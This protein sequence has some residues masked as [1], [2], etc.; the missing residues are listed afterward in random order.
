MAVAS[1]E[2]GGCRYSCELHGSGVGDL[3]L[4]FLTRSAC[5]RGL[6]RHAVKAGSWSA[7]PPSSRYGVFRVEMPLCRTLR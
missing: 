5:F 2:L 3:R 6:P 7:P 4:R 1:G